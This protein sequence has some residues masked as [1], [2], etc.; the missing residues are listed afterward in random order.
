VRGVVGA[1]AV[2]VQSQN[3]GGGLAHLVLLACLAGGRRRRG[4]TVRAC[5]A[6][7]I[8]APPPGTGTPPR[9]RHCPQA[10]PRGRPTMPLGEVEPVSE[11]TLHPNLARLAAAYDQILDQMA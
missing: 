3:E 7:A 9:F 4:R 6:R 1:H 11:S 8:T 10:R 2:Q 5:Q